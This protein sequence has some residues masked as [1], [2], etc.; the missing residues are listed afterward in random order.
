MPTTAIVTTQILDSGLTGRELIQAADQAA[1]QAILGFNPSDYGL[2]DSDNTWIGDNEFSETVTAT[3]LLNIEGT[4]N[5]EVGGSQRAY[6][7][8]TEGSAD[9]EFL[10]I[11]WS[12]NKAIISVQA[13]GIGV[14]RSLGFKSSSFRIESLT[15]TD[16]FYVDNNSLF[17][18]RPVMVNTSTIEPTADNY[19][20]LGSSTHRWTNT[21]SVD[22][23][24]SGRVSADIIG[25]TG[26]SP[27]DYNIH[28]TWNNFYSMSIYAN[29]SEMWK[30]GLG[31]TEIASNLSPTV[32][33][34]KTIGTLAK[35][36]EGAYFVDGSFSG[37]LD[38]EVGGS[39]RI[40]NLGSDADVAA[41]NSEYL[42]TS[43][44]TNVATISSVATGTGT[45][46]DITINANRQL[47]LKAANTL[48]IYNPG[49]VDYLWVAGN[50][51]K[52]SSFSNWELGASADIFRF[53]NVFSRSGSFSG[54]L[55]VEVG[56]EYRLFKLGSDADVAAGN[57]EY[58]SMRS[59]IVQSQESYVLEPV[60]TGTG[61]SARQFY[62]MGSNNRSLGH[63]LLDRYGAV[64]LKYGNTSNIYVSNGYTRAGAN[65]YPTT[66]NTYELGLATNRWSNVASVDGDFSGNV[67][68]SGLAT[69]E[70]ELQITGLLQA[71]SAE[72]TNLTVV[73]DIYAN[74]A[75]F[76][77]DITAVTIKSSYVHASPPSIYLDPAASH[78]YLRGL[79][80]TNVM[81]WDHNALI[82]YK[83]IQP[84][85]TVDLGTD[86]LRFNA[87][88]GID[89]S[90]TGTL[91]TEVGGS[92]RLFNLGSD[93]DVAS[94][95]SEYLETSFE[96]N[97][98]TI[99]AKKTGAGADR[100]LT[101]TS[102]GTTKLVG[103][104]TRIYAGANLSI[105]CYGTLSQFGSSLQPSSD[106]TRYNG[107]PSRRWSS[108]A[109]YA[110]DFAGTVTANAFV[111][112]G[113]GLTNLPAGGNP[114]DQSLNTTDSPS[115]V[116]GTFSGNAT[117]GIGGRVNW[118][119]TSTSIRRSGTSLYW[120]IGG[121][122][123]LTAHC[124]GSSK[125]LHWNEIQNQDIDFIVG[126]NGGRGIDMDGATGRVAFGTGI[127][128]EVGG[129]NRLFNLGSDA[130]VA[131]G[132]SEYLETSW[133]TNVA[134]IEPKSTGTGTDR[135]LRLGSG[136]DTRIDIKT[137]AVDVYA[138]GTS[139]SKFTFSS[140]SN[141]SRQQLAPSADGTLLCGT[142]TARWSDVYSVDGDFSGTVTADTIDSAGNLFSMNNQGVEFF[143]NQWGVN[144]FYHT[145]QSNN[146]SGFAI[147]TTKAYR[148]GADSGV[149]YGYSSGNLNKTTLSSAFEAWFLIAAPTIS[150]NWYRFEKDSTGF[151]FSFNGTSGN[152]NIYSCNDTT[153]TI[154]I[155]RGGTSSWSNVDVE[156]GGSTRI[157]NLGS[158]ADVAAGDTE[159][160]ELRYDANE[161]VI[162]TVAT[163]AGASRD[164]LLKRDGLTKLELNTKVTCHSDLT[165][166]NNNAVSC[167]GASKRWYA[168]Y[169]N[170]LDTKS[171]FVGIQ[172]V[173][174]TSDTLGD[175]DH[176]HL[177]DCTSNA[178]TIN[179]PAASQA[180]RR[181]EI[182]KIDA[183]SNAVTID[184]NGSETI[185]GATTITITSQYESVTIVSDGQDWFIV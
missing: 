113:S 155:L 66:D 138:N 158:D 32:D 41:G 115:F 180:G 139:V 84:S 2:L 59:D 163:G 35:R 153:K 52:P 92:N 179:L 15:G 184:G 90:F 171:F 170:R 145:I 88:Y 11:S 106:N 23:N 16:W 120:S 109:S 30:Y 135:T 112:D 104:Y 40:F 159:Y 56:G 87:Y 5:L 70:D 54:N 182:K 65:F 140:T 122:T 89:G 47:N 169:H 33:G 53:H 7:L 10:D 162:D 172:T 48:Y 29:G 168:S 161:A 133:D 46:R 114:F 157:F 27:T 39:N 55:D 68:I 45:T 85:G 150:A 42:E 26:F 148:F 147:Q 19:T 167:G 93:A 79:N 71:G 80:D 69:L 82:A 21:Y 103:T 37:T 185:D 34:T 177:C 125:K 111:G 64:S 128:T 183:T 17:L 110:G 38:T 144:N 152:E 119:N 3:S 8:G 176:T 136:G 73:D 105:N 58:L 57:S 141:I 20:T 160:L 154:S 124:G 174:G 100:S 142:P 94:G 123:A 146:T 49:S 127:S 96:S 101:I 165:P 181:Y 149:N 25:S 74:N 107:S 4:L 9:S 132:N 99:A 116:D 31:W 164:I 78:G 12:T 77:G 175:L 86:V 131:A 156:V 178:I 75:E 6:N 95:N 18:Q 166:L 13:T 173:T 62:I 143:K 36:F 98:A 130:D 134:L 44:D 51:L 91:D 129:S 43:W 102:D 61:T 67:T 83:R 151:K 1:A 126:Y 28:F 72:I 118:G 117:V 97:V 108:V 14:D 60:G 50:A 121:L 76:S 24:F 63:I 22:G 81:R 137:N